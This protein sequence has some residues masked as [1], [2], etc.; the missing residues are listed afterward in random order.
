MCIELTLEQ[1]WNILQNLDNNATTCI[2]MLHPYSIMIHQITSKIQL[3]NFQG[4][5]PT[6]GNYINLDNG[7]DQGLEH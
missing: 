7:K 5:N 2:N 3:T 1:V 4:S 6:I